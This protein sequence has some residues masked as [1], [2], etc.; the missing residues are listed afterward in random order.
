MTP[1]TSAS[2]EARSSAVARKAKAL[3]RGARVAVFAPASPGSEAK[4]KAGIAELRRLGF[5]ADLPVAQ[6]AEGYFAASAEARRVEFLRLLGDTKI[7]GLIGLRGG[8]GSN[9]LLD[10]SLAS[11]V[12]EPKAVMGFSDL[13]S[14]QIFLWQ[15]FRWVTFYGPMVAAGL[16]AGAGAAGGYDEKSLRS[17]IN[18]L[19]AGWKIS[20]RGEALVGGEAEGRLL[21]GA[22]TMVEATFGTPWDLD[23]RGVILILEDRGMKPYQVDRVLMHFKQAGKLDGVK[24]VVLGDFPECEPPIAG[25]PT[26]RDVCARI[27]GPLGVPVVFGAPV[28][29]TMRPMLTIPLGVNARLHAQGDGSLEILEAAVTR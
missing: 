26:V 10:A 17:S 24:G 2:S 15:Q 9:Y 20:L 27:L 16:D 12:G 7:D 3:E 25:S 4:V 1:N 5:A 23:T 14:L 13:T 11:G 19:G 29:H 6:R 28:G 22:M 18:E 8:Y 21:G